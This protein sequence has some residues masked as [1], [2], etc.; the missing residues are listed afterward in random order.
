MAIW[1]NDT[2]SGLNRT[3]VSDTFEPRTVED[4]VRVVRRNRST[5]QPL[6]V[7]GGRHAM[8]GQQFL[9]G[10]TL[11][12]MRRLNEVRGFDA[13]RGLLE[14]EAGILWPDVIRAY[15]TR[16]GGI[17]SKWG[18]RQKQ[19]GADRLTIGG[20]V[21]AN[22][23]GRGLTAPPFV[24]D[25]ESLEIVTA[26]G[27]LVT[28]SRQQSPELFRH[29]VGGYG[30]FGVVTAA[31]LRLTA[32]QQV[33]RVVELREID[34]LVDALRERISAGALYGDF[35]FATDP[36]N[37][38]FLRTGIL[39][40]YLPTGDLQPIPERQRRL[41]QTDW[42]RLIELAHRDKARAFDEF[43]GFYLATSGQRYWSDTHQ[44]NLYLE[45]YHAALDERLGSGIPGGEMITEL[46]V[47]RDRLAVFMDDVRRDLLRHPADVIYGTIRLIEP[48]TESALPWA[49][50]QYA[51]VIFNLHVDH[52]PT[53][54]AEAASAFV[55]LID[56]AIAHQGSYFLTYHRY[57]R[58]DQVFSCHPGISWIRTGCSRAIGIATCCTLPGTELV[59]RGRHGAKGAASI[60]YLDPG[61]ARLARDLA[62]CVSSAAALDGRVCQHPCER[63]SAGIQAF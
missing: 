33:E 63:S 62:A 58:A 41:S 25:L 5:G 47:P 17:N 30:L 42:N 38:R 26:D 40:C 53:A 3:S 39:S 18:I 34:G 27:E 61:P 35:Q 52:Q 45:S 29:A 28:C 36:A 20:A 31:T 60:G 12:D 16:P 49:R 50:E 15:L 2:H 59:R 11:L 43:A 56:H 46:Y 44:L 14:V 9:S 13:Q 32:R 6:A 51:C 55:R 21:G 1:V 57:A 10:G 54:I 22:I 37:T 8:G 24:S 23:H 48:D 7:A 19:T 4:V